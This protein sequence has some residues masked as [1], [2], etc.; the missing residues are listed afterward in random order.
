[1]Q[2][3][4]TVLA[5]E[6]RAR[7][8]TIG[9]T[10]HGGGDRPRPEAAD[11][12]PGRGSNRGGRIDVPCQAVVSR[13]MTTG[14]PARGPEATRSRIDAFITPSRRRS[15]GSTVVE[16]RVA[17]S[18]SST[19]MRPRLSSSPRTLLST[20][21]NT[22]ITSSC[23]G[24]RRTKRGAGQFPLLTVLQRALGGR[25]RLLAKRKGA[26]GGQH[27]SVTVIQRFGSALNLN[28]HFHVLVSEGV[29]VPSVAH[30]GAHR[31]SPRSSSDCWPSSALRARYS[32]RERIA[33][34]RPG[35]AR[36]L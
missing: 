9:W 4:G 6:L 25:L 36:R 14:L 12:C 24:R 32:T 22:A 1:M 20:R 16:L 18:S 21:R 13:P 15:S 23:R 3:G 5:G 17:P 10:L 34:L 33:W 26:R 2:G 8:H 30:G 29:W 28:V 19:S 35:D 31:T 27:A 7:R 11:G